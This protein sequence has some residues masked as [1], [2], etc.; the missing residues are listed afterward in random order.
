MKG[1]ITNEAQKQKMM[2]LDVD[3][4]E[5]YCSKHGHVKKSWEQD[6]T[7]TNAQKTWRSLFGC[8]E[9]PTRMAGTNYIAKNE[10]DYMHL[11]ELNYE[12][13]QNSI[14]VGDEQLADG[15]MD[16]NGKTGGYV[17]GLYSVAKSDFCKALLRP[18]ALNH[19]FT[20]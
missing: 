15:E 17:G 19:G 10:H 1:Q 4:I 9:V 14:E 20:V 18:G 13:P 3:K 6:C 16:W 11:H 8:F 2:F 12:T 5:K 7:M